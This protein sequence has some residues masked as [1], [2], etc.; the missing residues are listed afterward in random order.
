MS[1]CLGVNSPTEETIGNNPRVDPLDPME[2]TWEL[3]GAIAGCPTYSIH[4]HETLLMITLGID[5]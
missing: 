5:S 1:G 4:V 2:Q 3:L